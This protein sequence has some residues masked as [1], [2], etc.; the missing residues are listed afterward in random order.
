MGDPGYFKYFWL[1][2][3]RQKRN[4]SGIISIQVIAK[5]KGRSKLIKTIGS[6]D[7][8]EEVSRMVSEGAKWIT[9]TRGLTELD[10]VNHKQATELASRPEIG[11][12]E[13]TCKQYEKIR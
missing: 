11:L 12:H 9:E 3:V 7:K 13:L 2:F 5:H 6:S 1:M 4:K 10:F 8:A